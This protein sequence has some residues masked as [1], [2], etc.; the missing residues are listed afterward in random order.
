MSSDV[1]MFRRAILNPAR[2]FGEST[3][4]VKHPSGGPA[5]SHCSVPVDP[6]NAPIVDEEEDTELIQT[7]VCLSYDTL[8]LS[9]RDPASVDGKATRHIYP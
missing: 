9:C 7:E 2:N 4:D 5:A 3:N 1:G 6:T 8:S